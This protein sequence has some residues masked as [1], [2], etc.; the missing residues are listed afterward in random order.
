MVEMVD[1]TTSYLS[2]D[3]DA[4]YRQLNEAGYMCVG[5]VCLLPFLCACD[6]TVSSPGL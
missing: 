6:K 3:A 5:P 4:L 1:S 2:G